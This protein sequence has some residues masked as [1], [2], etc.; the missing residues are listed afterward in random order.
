MGASF[1]LLLLLLL[2]AVCLTLGPSWASERMKNRFLGGTAGI[3]FW[4]VGSGRAVDR[5][6]IH[7][8]ETIEVCLRCGVSY[9]IIMA[10]LRVDAKIVVMLLGNIAIDLRQLEIC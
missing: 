10:N 7:N 9:A 5:F 4:L 1:P 3:V 6:R 8:E 2:L